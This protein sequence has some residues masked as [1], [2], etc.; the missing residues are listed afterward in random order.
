M[1][2][3]YV[4]Q[5]LFVLIIPGYLFSQGVAK[6]VFQVVPLGVKGGIDESNLSAYMVARDGTHSYICFDAGTLYYG[7][8]KAIANKVF[9][10]SA[11]EVIRDYIKAYLISHAHLDHV[12]GLIIN[13]P[14]DSTKN[15]YALA[16]CVET[17][18]THYFTW[19]SWANFTDEGEVPLLKKYH[20]EVL[21]PDSI[22]N[23]INTQM[24]VVAFPLS[25]G[26]LQSTALLLKSNDNYILYL[27]DT[28]ADEI[29]KSNNLHLLW[30]HISP[31]IKDKKLRGMFIETSYPDAQPDKLLFGHL[32]PRWLMKEMDDLESLT[33]K[34][35]LKGFNVIITHNKPPQ[36]KI[37]M[38]KK[39]LKAENKL[40]LH[41]IFPEQGRTFEL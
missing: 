7:I 18:K 34:Q 33:G 3:K 5:L 16:S 27:G 22:V 39:Q 21:V 36:V 10:I 25:H 19:E 37:N 38:I 24:T 8:E 28:G 17:L 35:A 2:H 4:L 15:I 30:E 13:S 40:Q 31:I 29:E 32:T 11:E 12:A 1:F 26:N 9:S 41:L 14:D 23:I 20:Y 6:K